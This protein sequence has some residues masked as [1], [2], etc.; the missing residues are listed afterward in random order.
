M[1]NEFKITPKWSDIK[2]SGFYVYIHSRGSDGSPFY[3]GKGSGTRGWHRAKTNRGRLWS[4]TASKHGVSISVAQDNLSEES[5]FLLEM[6]LIAKLSHEGE[7]LV[8]VSIGGSGITT[9][10]HIPST[11][12]KISFSH[13]GRKVFCSNGME[14]DT[15]SE[16][17][18][19]LKSIGFSK[20]QGSGI[21]SCCRGITKSYLGYSWSYQESPE[22]PLVIGHEYSFIPVR[23]CDGKEYPSISAAAEAIRNEGF[24][25]KASGSKISRSAKSSHLRAYGYRW[26]YTS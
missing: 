22:E 5:A 20:A 6:W 11:K 24:Y 21:S 1:G 4:A 14:F 25:P 26:F 10:G 23:R 19:W 13:G 15:P 12:K 18:E 2:P 3:V 7:R 17:K 8:N 16:A 9:G